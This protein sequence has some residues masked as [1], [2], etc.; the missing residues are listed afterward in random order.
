MTKN[1]VCPELTRLLRL[2]RH[3]FINHIQ[4]VHALLQLGKAEKAKQYLE[5]L[6]KSPDLASSVMSDYRPE[7]CNIQALH[8]PAGSGNRVEEK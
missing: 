1:E 5:D 4:V 3:E 7:N 6:A 2:Q 8:P